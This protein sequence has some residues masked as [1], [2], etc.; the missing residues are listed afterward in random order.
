[1]IKV[2]YHK[3]KRF[4]NLIEAIK[5]DFLEIIKIMK[6]NDRYDSK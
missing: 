4:S 3:L 2:F 6:E 1:M 5:I